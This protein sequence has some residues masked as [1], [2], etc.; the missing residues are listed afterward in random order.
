M[1]G[2][3]WSDHGLV[4]RQPTK[5]YAG[6]GVSPY[7]MLG[8]LSVTSMHPAEQFSYCHLSSTVFVFNTPRERNRQRAI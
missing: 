2:N 8:L 5:I 7:E 4:F 1:V 3:V 6:N